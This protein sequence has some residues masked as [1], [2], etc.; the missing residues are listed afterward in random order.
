M[1]ADVNVGAFYRGIDLSA[2]V[3][4]MSEYSSRPVDT[5]SIK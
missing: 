5:F 2:I 3:A 1:V 4:I